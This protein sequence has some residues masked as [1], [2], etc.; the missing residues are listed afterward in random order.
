MVWLNRTSLEVMGTDIGA[1]NPLNVQLP[2]PQEF[3]IMGMPG[4]SCSSTNVK[5]TADQSSRNLPSTPNA[6][7]LQ[8]P[9]ASG[10]I[11][12]KVFYAEFDADSLN[13]ILTGTQYFKLKP[14][15]C[16]VTEVSQLC[17]EYLNMEDD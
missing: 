6:L 14:E 2:S 5:T 7:S 15:Q 1:N 3:G 10:E 8:K 11:R 16:K 4:T 13:P 12:R 9:K 17:K